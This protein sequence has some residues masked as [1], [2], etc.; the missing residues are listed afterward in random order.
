VAQGEGP[1][2]KSQTEKKIINV[3]WIVD[4]KV[5]LRTRVAQWYSICLA[6]Q[7]L[8]LISSIAKKF[9]NFQRLK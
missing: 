1:E 6:W 5:K 8:S 3:R 7:S 4:L 9:L 2:F